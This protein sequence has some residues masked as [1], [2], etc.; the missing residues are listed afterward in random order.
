MGNLTLYRMYGLL[1]L[2]TGIAV[3]LLYRTIQVQK[4]DRSA[5]WIGASC[6]FG[7]LGLVFLSTTSDPLHWVGLALFVT[8][9]SLLH[10]AIGSATR[11]STRR[12]IPW[13]AGF[14]AACFLGT[15]VLAQLIPVLPIHRAPALFSVSFLQLVNVWFLLRQKDSPTRLANIAMA[16]FL[17]LHVVV[18]ASRTNRILADA[19]HSRWLTY[20][21]MTIVV[22]MGASFLSMEALRSRHDL[23]YI[24]MTDPL[25]G[26]LNR[27]ALEVI[28]HR[29]LQRCIRLHK[30]CSALMMDID[31]FKQIND[32]MGHAAGDSA[33]RAVAGILQAMLRPTD[34]ITRHGGDEFFIMLPECAADNAAWIVARLRQAIQAC[35]LRSEDATLFGIQASIGLT[36]CHGSNMTVQTLLHE[37]DMALYQQK[38]ANRQMSA[39]PLADQPPEGGAHVHPSNA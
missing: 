7:G 37:S 35:T 34:V 6:F 24:A 10:M 1:L 8:M 27:R 32:H 11:Q 39:F 16:I 31:F 12:T 14:T 17:A 3:A 28:A 2:S 15:V 21:G 26:L 25:T 22:G 13:I 18:L 29:E 20:I 5:Y 36:T 38:Q 23:E 4:H 30:P 9:P 33:L 19:D